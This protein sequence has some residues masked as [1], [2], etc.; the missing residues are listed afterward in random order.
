M[1]PLKKLKLDERAV[2]S[3]DGITICTRFHSVSYICCLISFLRQIYLYISF[4]CEIHY[5]G[6]QCDIY[7][8]VSFQH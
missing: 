8:S 6:Q 5:F 2:T 3:L 4:D 1:L 7:T